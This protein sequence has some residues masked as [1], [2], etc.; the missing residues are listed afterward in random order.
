MWILATIEK[1]LPY[2]DYHA[3]LKE[4]WK[5]VH[6]HIEDNSNYKTFFKAV[7]RRGFVGKLLRRTVAPFK[8]VKPHYQTL[9][10]PVAGL[11]VISP[12]DSRIGD[13]KGAHLPV[14]QETSDCLTSITWD[15]WAALSPKTMK[16]LGIKQNQVISIQTEMCSLEV[17]AYPMPGLHSDVVVVPQGNGYKDPRSTI[18]NG[19][20]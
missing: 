3:Y 13:G 4:K 18:S 6:R 14:L 11:V 16:K 12:L 17:A 19:G 9:A 10:S 5:G 20:T 1:N 7:L 2:A 15:S 8:S